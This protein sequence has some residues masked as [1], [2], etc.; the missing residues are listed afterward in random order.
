MKTKMKEKS[1]ISQFLVIGT[2]TVINMILGLLTTPIITRIVDPVDYGQLSMF[3]TY[4]N[5]A[6]MV[7][8][9]GLDQSLIRFFYNHD[10]VEYKRSLVSFCVGLSVSTALC[11]GVAFLFGIWSSILKFEFSN[12]IATIFA[13][14][15][16]FLLIDRFALLLLRLTYK[17]KIYSMC[18]VIQEIIYVV[19]SLLWIYIVKQKYLFGLCIATLLSVLGPLT[20]GIISC[21]TYWRYSRKW[22]VEKRQI[23]I[24][25]IPII[26]SSGLNQ[27][28]NAIDKISLNHY[29]T[30]VEVG[31]YSSAISLVSIFA[32]IQSTFNAIWA[33]TQ[34]E[35]YQKYP[36]DKVYYQRVNQIVTFVMFFIG[37]HLILFKDIFALLLGEKYRLA[38]QI[39]PFLMFQPIMYTLSETTHIGITI[40]KKSYL[41]IVISGV[42]CLINLAGNT[43]LVPLIGYK[44]AAISTGISYIVFFALRTFFSNRYYFVDYKLIRLTIVTGLTCIFAYHGTFRPFDIFSIAIYFACVLSLFF[45]YWP[46]VKELYSILLNFVRRNNTT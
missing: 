40:K 36:D 24:F 13:L 25:G 1:F 5:I 6:V 46:Y 22:K 43:F 32:I 37:I 8:C 7:L 33:P 45:L 2:G 16:V 10:E 35:H 28:F 26:L 38:S 12:P 14:Y 30:Y 34:I 9:L 29:C 20:I 15:I 19:V 41:G 21:R 18:S 17:S 27:L 23:L 3:N 42:S 39:L 31:V 4:A 44:G 11:V